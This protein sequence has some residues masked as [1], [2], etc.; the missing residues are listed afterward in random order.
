MTGRMQPERRFGPVY[1][2]VT[3]RS[4]TSVTRWRF[5]KPLEENPELV[6]ALYHEI[7]R[8]ASTGPDN[9][10]QFLLIDSDLVEPENALPGFVQ[11]RLAGEPDAPSLISYYSGP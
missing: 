1:D 7:Y 10:T 4:L 3:I 2:S 8:L 6:Q 11:R 9:A 5:T